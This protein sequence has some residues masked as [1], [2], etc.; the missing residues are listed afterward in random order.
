MIPRTCLLF[1]PILLLAQEQAPPEVDQE[2]RARVNGFYQDFVEGSFSPRK[3]E[4][5]I[6]DDTKDYFYN[7]GK[8]KFISFRID[9]VTYSDDF[10]K[11]QVLV[12]GKETKM[13][14]GHTVVMDAPMDTHW[15]IEGGNGV[16]PTIPG[17]LLPRPWEAR[18]PIPARKERTRE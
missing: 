8:R 18:L 11:A 9:T 17:T 1:L 12:V 7:T 13:V 6:A 3:A 14:L 15:K 4:A 2:L 16:G 5:F 10:T